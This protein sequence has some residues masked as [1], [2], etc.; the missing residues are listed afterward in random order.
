MFKL[1]T[2]SE[3]CP[4][5]PPMG[6]SPPSHAVSHWEHHVSS[7]SEETCPVCSPSCCPG[8]MI[9]H[10]AL[11]TCG[12]AGKRKAATGTF[13]LIR[14][15]STFVIKGS[16]KIITFQYLHMLNRLQRSRHNEVKKERK[17]KAWWDIAGRDICSLWFGAQG[18]ETQNPRKICVGRDLKAHPVLPHG[19][20]YLLLDQTA[21]NPI[22]PGQLLLPGKSSEREG[23]K[24]TDP[25]RG[26]GSDTGNKWLLL[27]HSKSAADF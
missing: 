23:H 18:A 12:S 15:V 5:D 20:G 26:R 22:Q 10:P 16:L 8:E 21:P 11:A 27:I 14:T 1:Q 25:S 7:V 4:W 17:I 19:Q 2:Q 13:L 24:R 9:H 6:A 3:H